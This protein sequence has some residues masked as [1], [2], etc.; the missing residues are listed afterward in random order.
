MSGW[1]KVGVQCVCV[2]ASDDT[3]GRATDLIEGAVYTIKNWA[4]TDPNGVR[5]VFLR[6]AHAND[7]WLGFGF[8]VD[9]FRP[10]VDLKD[11]IAMFHAL[12]PGLPV[13]PGVTRREM[14]PSERLDALREYVK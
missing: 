6:E 9:R 4:E 7:E 12:C 13:V 5:G 11:D 3:L 14:M 1:V 10:I 2:D 8:R